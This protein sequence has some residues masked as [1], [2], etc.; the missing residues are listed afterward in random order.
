[1]CTSRGTAV[2]CC[3]V[4]IGTGGEVVRH[5]AIEHFAA[6]RLYRLCDGCVDVWY[7]LRVSTSVQSY[8]TTYS[9]TSAACVGK[10]HVTTL[11]LSS[12][13]SFLKRTAGTVLIFDPV[14]LSSVD[15]PM[16]VSLSNAHTSILEESNSY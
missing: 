12:S 14:L 10:V 2:D 8:S 1:M 3:L 15:P 7:V 11:L 4:K 6:V 16:I 5:E 9:T 13:P